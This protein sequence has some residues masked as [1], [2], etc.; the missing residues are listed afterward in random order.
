MIPNPL[1]H[2]SMEDKFTSSCNSHATLCAF[3]RPDKKKFSRC[4]TRVI[5][6]R[7]KKLRVRKGENDENLTL[8]P[9]LFASVLKFNTQI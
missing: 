1:F 3:S 8:G 7:K 6:V 4:D 5:K 2:N 9:V